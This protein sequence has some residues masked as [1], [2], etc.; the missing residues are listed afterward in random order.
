MINA[1]TVTTCI[2][3]V[4]KLSGATLSSTYSTCHLGQLLCFSLF[5]DGSLEKVTSLARPD[6]LSTWIPEFVL[7][8]IQWLGFKFVTVN[9]SAYLITT[10]V[11][12][13]MGRAV[14]RVGWMVAA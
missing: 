13:R 8:I 1:N 9:T 4:E 6:C 11:A 7:Y 3:L 14:G 12:R 10:C 2:W 5:R